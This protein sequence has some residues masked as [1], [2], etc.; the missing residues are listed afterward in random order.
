M[1]EFECQLHYSESRREGWDHWESVRFLVNEFCLRK[2]EQE[3]RRA[4]A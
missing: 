3:R 4:D 1:N 2:R